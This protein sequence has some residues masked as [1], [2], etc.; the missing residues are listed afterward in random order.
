MI[1]F[2]LISLTAFTLSSCSVNNQ[3]PVANSQTEV[4]AGE[5][6]KLEFRDAIMPFLGKP[7]VS[8]TLEGNAVEKL[9]INL[10][11]VDCTTFV[12]YVTASMLSNQSVDSITDA[13]KDALK[14]LRYRNGKIDG[15][16]S[17][18]H[19]FSEWISDN[20]RRGNVTEITGDFQNQPFTEK[21]GYMSTHPD[22][23][24]QLKDNPALVKK[25][26]ASEDYVNSLETFYIPKDMIAQQDSLIKEGDII[27]ITT[28]MPG[29]E[30]A[31]V[32]FAVIQNGVV[33]LLHASTDKKMVLI[34]PRPLS[35]YLAGNKKQTGIKVVRINRD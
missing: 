4:S 6:K 25:I 17:R 18:L 31:H 5:T 2:I 27:A 26:K 28:D 34:D 8:A 9:V 11:S 10:D 32:G 7:Y 19:Y 15:Y 14:S 1:Q 23:Y 16:A 30:I 13:Y 20:Q 12:E 24:K 3:K 22:K 21:A 29:L 33:H 35:E